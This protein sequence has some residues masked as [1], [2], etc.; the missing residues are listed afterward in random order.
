[1]KAPQVN[2]GSALVVELDKAG[3]LRWQEVALVD[4]HRDRG[5]LLGQDLPPAHQRGNERKIRAAGRGVVD[6][7]SQHVA[8]GIQGACGDADLCIG[9]SG[10]VPH[11]SIG[12]RVIVDVAAGHVDPADLL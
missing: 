8:A 7:D 2:G 1:M 6:T 11:C 10:G 12:L 4:Q 9:L 3:P 5:Q